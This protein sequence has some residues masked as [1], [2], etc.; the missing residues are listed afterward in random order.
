MV[1]ATVGGGV[2]GDGG[3]TA[4]S[5]SSP[6]RLGTRL[7]VTQTELAPL[8][9]LPQMHCGYKQHVVGPS[10]V[11]TSSQSSFVEHAWTK[12]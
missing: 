5:S 8:F 9:A 2:G 3:E 4:S 11:G 1:D 6:V 10:S 12:I 7:F